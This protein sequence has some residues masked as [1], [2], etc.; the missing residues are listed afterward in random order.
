MA[1]L[2][3]AWPPPPEPLK[4]GINVQGVNENRSNRDAINM[5]YRSLQQ[6]HEQA[7]IA[8]IIQQL[9]EVIDE[10]IETRQGRSGKNPDPYDIS[11]IDF[12][13][14][15]RK[16]ERSPRKKTTVQNLRQALEDRL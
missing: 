10:A 15:R 12:D 7:D 2:I 9:H 14:L 11:R 4:A 8:N 16:F 5:V 3:D 13:L 6:D 1:K